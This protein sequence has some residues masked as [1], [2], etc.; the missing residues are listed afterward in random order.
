MS[1]LEHSKLFTELVIMLKN[2]MIMLED[3][4]EESAEAT[5]RSLWLLASGNSVSVERAHVLDLPELTEIEVDNL[6]ENVD[7]RL[8]GV[9]LTHLTNRQQFM[10]VDF[11]V[12]SEALVPRKETELLGYGALDLLNKCTA[13]NG[14]AKVIDVCTGSGNLALAFAYHQSKAKVYAAD[15]SID[16]V[17][18]ARRNNTYMD[19]EDRVVFYTGD[20]LEPF[21]SEEYYNKVDLLTCNPPYISSGK[22]ERMP[23]QIIEFE[24]GLAFDGGPFGIKILT[25]LIKEAPKYLANE[26]WLAFE[27]GLGQGE[28]MMKRLKKNK[29]YKALK[30]LK[31][32]NGEIRAIMAQA[33]H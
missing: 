31:N 14:S 7:R 32:T 16:A 26:G 4:P 30:A 25:R 3:K 29:D 21:E 9:P 11:M 12:G 15:L 1:R 22:L 8:K 19:L 5:L 10:G 23:N 17:E 2:K 24:P 13:K 28:P 18:L 20:L 6:K 27:L 33:N